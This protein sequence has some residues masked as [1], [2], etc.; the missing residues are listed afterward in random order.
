MMTGLGQLVYYTPDD[1]LW[2]GAQSQEALIFLHGLGGGSSAYEWSKVYP[3][4]ASDFRVLAPDMMGWGRSAHPVRDYKAEDYIANIIEFMAQACETPT[5]VIASAV[6]AAFAI[7]A[8]IL[9]P[10]LFKSLILINPA[11]L[12]E[13]GRNYRQSGF[14]RF[15]QAIKASF[16][17]RWLYRNSV[18]TRAGIRSFLEK[19]QFADA[20]KISP[21]IIEAYLQSAKQENADCAALSFVRGDLCFDLSEYISELTVPAVMIWGKE[22]EFMGPAAGRKLAEM[23]PRVIRG[24]CLLDDVGFTPQLEQPAVTIGLIRKFLPCLNEAARVC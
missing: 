4:F 2:P 15:A 10:D 18:A 12:E 17:S 22:S 13:F 21:E 3:A 9:R 19:R 5:T 6:T 14:A 1:E 11:G 23:N 20:V 24:F 8:A 7:R 16:I